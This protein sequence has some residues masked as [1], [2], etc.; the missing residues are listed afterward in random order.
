MKGLPLE[1]VAA[2]FGDA[3]EVAIYQR[4]IEVDMATHT[5]V[6]RQ[7]SASGVASKGDSFVAATHVEHEKDG[8]RENTST[9]SGGKL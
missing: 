8:D 6:G 5:I 3:D 1:E 2:I 4:D 7:H 9:E